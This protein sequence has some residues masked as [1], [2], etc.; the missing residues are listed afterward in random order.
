MLEVTP[1]GLFVIFFD[2]WISN[3][4]YLFGVGRWISHIE[5]GGTLLQVMWKDKEQIGG[6]ATSTSTHLGSI[7][8]TYV[9][10]PHTL[11]EQHAR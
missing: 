3:C 11:E 10:I 5:V 1:I 6:G 7:C 2:T 8:F 4:L 9:F